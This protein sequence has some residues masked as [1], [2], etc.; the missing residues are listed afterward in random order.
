[1]LRT[2][3]R[4]FLAVLVV[5]AGLVACQSGSD[6]PVQ[7]D[8]QDASFT[9]LNQDSTRVTFPD[10]FRG[11]ILVIG[12]VYTQCPDVC[13]MTTAN[14]MNVR[15]SLGAPED[16]RFVTISFDPE[17]D[18]P[19]RL[20]GYRD[21]YG[22]EETSWAFLTGG[23]AEVDSLMKRMGIRHEPVAMDGSPVSIDTTSNYL[24]NHSDQI[25]LI[26]ENGRVRM[27]YSGSR[28]PPK[29]IVEDVRKLQS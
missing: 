23:E 9:L 3:L 29:Y 12:F 7:D 25:T 14:M 10:D 6:L 11:E 19:S 16:V 21:A 22:L 24:I 26:D 28:T 13:P 1:M 18:S 27:E 5:A 2:A 8:L 15:D 4:P 20:A 17:R